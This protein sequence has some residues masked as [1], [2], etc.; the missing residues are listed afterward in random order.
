MVGPLPFG[1]NVRI[2]HGSCE[3]IGDDK[4]IESP[5]DVPSPGTRT[6]RPPGIGPFLIRVKVTEGIKEPFRQK[7]GKTLAFLIRKTRILT[8]GL[9]VGQIDLAM[10]DV[11]V[12]AQDH[13][14]FPAQVD[15]VIFQVGI[16]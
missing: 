1:K 6:V 7:I 8:V 9:W 10:S 5:P 4:I 3:V 16:P 15:Q 11:Q 14:F 2:P 13:G 12:T